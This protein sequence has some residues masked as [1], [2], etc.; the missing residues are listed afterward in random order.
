[1]KKIIIVLV[2]ILTILVV[3][4]GICT[5]LAAAE[6]EEGVFVDRLGEKPVDLADLLGDL[7]NGSICL[8]YEAV[9]RTIQNELENDGDE[10]ITGL[11]LAPSETENS[12]WMR[13]QVCYAE[14]TWTVTV[15]MQIKAVT[16]SKGVTG[17][18]L[19]PEEIRL[20]KLPV[21]EMLWPYLLNK[22]T[23]QA[24]LTFE[25]GVV[26]YDLP[27]LDLK[28]VQVKDIRAASDGFVLELGMGSL[29]G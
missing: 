10:T 18:A 9:N 5:V 15:R 21:P 24:E 29:W 19:T 14:R 17:L 16:G 11:I 13:V 26:S 4:T 23:E 22:L 25:D 6:P 27:D 7:L 12:L 20:G 8:P 1:M 28:L 3:G 2:S